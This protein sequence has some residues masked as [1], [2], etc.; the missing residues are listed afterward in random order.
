MCQ[1]MR[2]WHI[3]RLPMQ[4]KP[5]PGLMSRNNMFLEKAFPLF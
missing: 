1:E 3:E 5:L 2:K 4:T